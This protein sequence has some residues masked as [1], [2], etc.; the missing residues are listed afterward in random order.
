MLAECLE[1]AKVE[2]E[3]DTSSDVDD[4]LKDKS[5]LDQIKQ[6]SNVD[7]PGLDLDPAKKP[8]STNVTTTLL[9]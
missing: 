9:K 8:S 2:S 4:N 7:G 1:E 3:Q 6:V 5:L